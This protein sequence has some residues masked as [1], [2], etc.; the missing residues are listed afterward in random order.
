MTH[1]H[2]AGH[3]HDDHGNGEHGHEHE[4]EHDHDNDHG[5]GHGHSHAHGKAPRAIVRAMVVTLIFMGIEVAGGLISNSL[6]LLS[7]AGHMLTD[8]GA[9]LLSLFAIWVARRPS[10]ASMTFGYHRAEILG[11]LISGLLIWL[12]AGVLV[13]EAIGRLQAPPEVNGRVLLGVAAIGLLANLASLG[14]LHSAKKENIN[15]RAAYL[16]I[17]ADSLGSV[18]AIL[19]G[20]ILMLTGWRPIDPIVTIVFAGLMLYSSWHLIKEALAVLM[21]SAPSGMD[22]QQ[23]RAELQAVPGVLEVHDLHIW[24]VSSGRL[25]L[26]V[27]LVAR[28]S[29]Q[30]ILHEANGLLEKR[31][32]IVHTTIQVEHPDRFS[33]KRC[34]EC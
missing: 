8:V 3:G 25:A 24:S 6:A 2:D 18:G 7:D 26:S 12:I 14:M 15:V 1:N 5:H 34:Y 21:E 23:V 22:P 13:F 17:V 32:R 31:F 19:A 10:T 33:S 30:Q 9:M 27:H 29:E 4:H 16:H 11:A 20:V 28:D